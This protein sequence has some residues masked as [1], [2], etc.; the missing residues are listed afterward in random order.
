LGLG[1]GL[2]TTRVDHHVLRE[3]R[4]L[5][6]HAGRL[7]VARHR[8]G[9]KS[10]EERGEG[11]D[12]GQHNVNGARPTHDFRGVPRIETVAKDMFGRALVLAVMAM[13]VDGGLQRNVALSRSEM[14]TLEIARVHV[15]AP[16]GIHSGRRSPSSRTKAPYSS[17][18]EPIYG[19]KSR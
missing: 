7:G 2:G 15:A 4:R 9:P 3:A 5:C 10:R 16:V 6:H 13:D 1:E 19:G 8:I 18:V 12:D 14:T 17:S 11:R